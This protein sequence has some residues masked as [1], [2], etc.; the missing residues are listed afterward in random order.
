MQFP[1][2]PLRVARAL[3]ASALLS[4]VVLPAPAQGGWSRFNDLPGF[5]IGG[6]VFALGTWR[7]ELVAGMYKNVQKDGHALGH[8][9]HF[10]GERWHPFGSGLDGRVR[11]VIEFGG[12]LYVGGAFTLAGGVP[13]ACVAR[14][15]GT[16]WHPVGAGFDGEVWTLAVHRGELYAGGYFTASGATP[17]SRLARWDGRLWQPVGGGVTWAFGVYATVRALASDGSSLFVG[18]EFDRAGSVPAS[19]VAAWDGNSWR[20]LGGGFNGFRWGTVW[21]LA[22]YRGRLYAGGYFGLAGNLPVDRIAAW[23]GTAWASVDNGV[24]H[25][26]SDC[27]VRSLVVHGTDLYVGGDFV[28]A[29]QQT[30]DRVARFDGTR[31]HAIGG[32]DVA[33]SQP[34]TVIAMTSWNGQLYCGGE[35]HIA[36][37]PP[38]QGRTSA[39]YHIAS[40]DGA[41]W[42]SVGRGLGFDGWVSMLTHWR[43]RVVA[44][45][46]FLIAGGSYATQLAMF[47]GD[48]WQ[49][50][51][52]FDGVVWD[53]VEHLGDLYVAG[54]FTLGNGVARFDGQQWHTLGN[55]PSLYRALSI[56]VYQNA[57]HVGT[58]GKPRR[59]NGAAWEEF[60]IDVSGAI[61]ALHV[62][63]G[64]LYL[65]GTTPFMPGKPNLLSW[66]GATM[67]IVGGGTNGPVDALASHGGELIV[68]GSFTSAGSVP[69]R[70]IA[71][72]DGT[73]FATFGA[74]I[75]G[76]GVRAITTLRG[77][78][79]VG[80]DFSRGQG[81]NADYL[82]RWNGTGWQSF[83]GGDPDGPVFAL[84]PDDARGELHVGGGFWRTGG[85]DAESYGLWQ[86][87]VSWSDLPGALGS[88]RR[89]PVLWGEGSLQPG[90]PTRIVMTS[91]AEQAIAVLVLGTRRV[92][93]PFL[94]G[95]L[96]PQPNVLLAIT[97]DRIG[98]FA[99]ETPWPGD[100]TPQSSWYWQAWVLDPAGPLG[101]TATNGLQLRV[102]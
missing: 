21:A 5:G 51:G 58:F 52:N 40:F 36:G 56:A 62:H 94:G 24:R 2:S 61:T 68:G 4:A 72:W 53:A 76:A 33:E 12:D 9:A 87:A 70:S 60:G 15:D 11:T 10:D 46:R 7:N 3:V 1:V 35:F 81:E 20:A 38:R 8:V 14:W 82:A 63:N 39:V 6:R 102:P 45:G 78:L 41:R 69:A 29:G 54:E 37:E 89:T 83:A 13:A 80:G 92:D 19:H 85:I 99:F 64:L 93:V 26:T 73:R 18:G 27:E 90:A 47:D 28:V 100:L 44:G 50:L 57:I 25:P 71:R 74:G 65:G 49:P 101:A 84:L 98:R 77:E 79:V 91:A 75:R 22:M 43:G 59:W 88:P 30:V 16:R 17:V 23:D 42:S 67:G 95:T 97:T 55:G 66:D 48:D 34:P 86:A 31:F 32:I 96:V